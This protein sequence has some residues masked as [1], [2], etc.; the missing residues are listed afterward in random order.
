MFGGGGALVGGGVGV[1]GGVERRGGG[2]V[3]GYRW[4]H[5]QLKNKSLHVIAKRSHDQPFLQQ[6]PLETDKTAGM[7]GQ[8]L[9][10]RTQVPEDGEKGVR[11]LR[12]AAL[13]NGNLILEW[14]RFQLSAARKGWEKKLPRAGGRFGFKRSPTKRKEGKDKERVT[15]RRNAKR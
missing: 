15:I 13:L 11:L 14:K 10:L 9:G 7:L 2:G 5:K 1:G 4:F 3:L 12:I 8:L 6:L